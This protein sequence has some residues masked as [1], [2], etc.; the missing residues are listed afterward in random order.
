MKTA[1][2]VGR[3]WLVLPDSRLRGRPPQPAGPGAHLRGWQQRRARAAGSAAAA[4]GAARPRARTGT[5]APASFA[6]AASAYHL[7]PPP[8]AGLFRVPA[9]GRRSASG[10]ADGLR[11]MPSGRHRVRQPPSRILADSSPRPGFPD[12]RRRRL[13]GRSPAPR[14]GLPQAPP[15]FSLTLSALSL[16][17][18]PAPAVQP[19]AEVPLR[20]RAEGTPV[21]LRLI[22]YISQNRTH[23]LASLG[24]RE[25]KREALHRACASLLNA[26]CPLRPRLLMG[27]SVPDLALLGR[28]GYG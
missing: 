27:G 12:R 22:N 19:G 17:F 18:P 13:G 15:S 14:P 3:V 11:L 7:A 25:A 8:R 21:T 16:A 10:V 24:G 1:L 26:S 2:R 4:R 28:R 20:A 9:E 23:S 6:L 5:A